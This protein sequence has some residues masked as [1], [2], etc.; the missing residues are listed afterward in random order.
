MIAQA[1]LAGAAAVAAVAPVAET[2]RPRAE[3]RF[4]DDFG[5]PLR[6][7]GYD[8]DRA[9]VVV[10]TP[11]AMHL[12]PASGRVGT[13]EP[14]TVVLQGVASDATVRPCPR[15]RIVA[16]YVQ[17][18]ETGPRSIAIHDLDGKRLASLAARESEEFHSILQGGAG[19]TIATVSVSSRGDPRRSSWFW[20]LWS[21]K[22]SRLASW[23]S[24]AGVKAGFDPTGEYLLLLW[25][26]HAEIRDRKGN[27]TER[28]IDGR[29]HKGA[30]S[31]RAET[32]V[33]GEAVDRR[34]LVV[35]HRRRSRRI[36]APSPIHGVAV[37]PDGESVWAWFRDGEVRGVDVSGGALEAPV[38]WPAELGEATITSFEAEDGGTALVALASRSGP[39]EPY[40]PST[41]AR[42]GGGTVLS[43]FPFPT[44]RPTAF[45]PAVISI[46][47]GMVSWNRD[48]LAIW[49]TG[50]GPRR[51][52]P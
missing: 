40:G 7:L 4:V 31:E 48:R 34:A 27:V 32:V 8:R 52:G 20:D 50:R 26:D 19:R 38:A 35:V 43:T 11:G 33:L 47:E 14:R 16:S 9:V 24:P 45:L 37:A 18:D 12:V 41:L 6:G 49:G 23:T 30:L 25:P 13:T 5:G 28:P 3:Y 39:S 21:S 36:V 22:G 44:A 51:A 1:L 46:P 15:G 10:A 42:V 2:L 17:T 29:F